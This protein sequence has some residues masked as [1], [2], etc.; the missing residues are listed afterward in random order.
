MSLSSLAAQVKGVP[1][2]NSDAQAALDA[3]LGRSIPARFLLPGGVPDDDGRERERR[4]VDLEL[5]V[6]SVDKEGPGGLR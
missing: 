6:L 4:R 3:A 1:P 2:L 5:H